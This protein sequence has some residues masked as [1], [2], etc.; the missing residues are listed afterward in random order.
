MEKKKFTKRQ[1]HRNKK[2]NI[3]MELCICN[4][5]YWRWMELYVFLSCIF[6]LSGSV[7]VFC[8]INQV[9]ANVREWSKK[10]LLLTQAAAKLWIQLFN[11]LD[12][13]LIRIW[14]N[15]RNTNRAKATIQMR[16]KHT[17]YDINWNAQGFGIVYL[18]AV[19]FLLNISSLLDPGR[20]HWEAEFKI[21]VNFYVLC[22]FLF[23]FLYLAKETDQKPEHFQETIGCLK[24]HRKWKIFFVI[25]WWCFTSAMFNAIFY[26]CLPFLFCFGLHVCK[27][28]WTSDIIIIK[29]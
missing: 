5:K 27:G 25:N 21:R 18:F 23:L 8:A 28:H 1:C 20:R 19:W 12:R 29:K 22:T 9:H 24:T 13:F 17:K 3:K 14:A 16:A 11:N 7:L 2:A 4:A 26:V 10:M 6:T 15:E